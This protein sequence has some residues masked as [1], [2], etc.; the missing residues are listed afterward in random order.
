VTGELPGVP[1]PHEPTEVRVPRL[2]A[3]MEELGNELV[4]VALSAGPAG[5]QRAEAR[6]EQ[7]QREI[8]AL[9]HKVDAALDQEASPDRKLAEERAKA[10]VVA[11]L[12]EV[13]SS[14]CG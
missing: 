6:A 5:D 1:E 7:I 3:R 9:A 10:E 12:R 8:E 4:E 14:N 2:L 11:R 13:L